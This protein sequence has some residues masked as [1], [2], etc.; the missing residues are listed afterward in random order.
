[1]TDFDVLLNRNQKAFPGLQ[2][3]KHKFGESRKN[4]LNKDS[5]NRCRRRGSRARAGERAQ[6]HTGRRQ[7]RALLCTRT[8]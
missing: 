1:M 8:R 3:Q 7:H 6:P 5:R 2:L 4:D